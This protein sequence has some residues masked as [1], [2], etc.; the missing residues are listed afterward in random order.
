MK[1]Q[2]EPVVDILIE[3]LQQLGLGV[4]DAVGDDFFQ[5]RLQGIEGGFDLLG[6]ATG[7]VDLEDAFRKSRP[8]SMRPSTSSLAPNTPENRLNFR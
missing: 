5:L 4:F 1:T 8:P 7:V 3:I 6:L 2:F